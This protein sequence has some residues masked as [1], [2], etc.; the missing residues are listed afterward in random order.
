MHLKRTLDRSMHESANQ[1]RFHQLGQSKLL[2]LCQKLVLLLG[3]V[4]APVV[5][6]KLTLFGNQTNLQKNNKSTQSKN[7]ES[8]W[9]ALLGK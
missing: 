4:Y 8:Y 1:A 9:R 2:L 3:D 6:N 7:I 5:S